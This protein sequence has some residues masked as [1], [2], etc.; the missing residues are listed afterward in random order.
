MIQLKEVEEYAF[1]NNSKNSSYYI[2]DVK[3]GFYYISLYPVEPTIE[4]VDM[5]DN[6]YIKAKKYFYFHAHNYAN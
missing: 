4:E 5:N 2:E 6:D 1:F 3:Y